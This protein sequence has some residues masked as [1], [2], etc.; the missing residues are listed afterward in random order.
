MLRHLLVVAIPDDLAGRATQWVARIVAVLLLI[1]TV[2]GRMPDPW[3][4]AAFGSEW[5]VRAVLAA[6]SLWVA[7]AIGTILASRLPT[8]PYVVGRRLA[9][10]TWGLPRHVST[11]ALES[12]RIERRPDPWGE[13]IVV[14]LRDGTNH[15][16]CPLRWDRADRLFVKLRKAT[17]RRRDLAATIDRIRSQRTRSGR[18]RPRARP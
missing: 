1:G 16:L 6:V 9:L 8:A 18:A 13:T 7:D 12:V 4:A 14:R 10:P 17:S 5:I 11:K 2:L 15:D 3:V